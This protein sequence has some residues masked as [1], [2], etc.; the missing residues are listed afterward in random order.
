MLLALRLRGVAG[1]LEIQRVAASWSCPSASPYCCAVLSSSYAKCVDS[2]SACDSLG[3]RTLGPDDEIP[4][5]S[6]RNECNPAAFV[7]RW[8]CNASCNV[9]QIDKDAKCPD[10]VTGSATGSNEDEACREAKRAATQ[11]TPKGC[12]P[13]HC[14]CDC[15]KG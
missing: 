8:S 10:R 15:T 12:Y 5:F 11:S 6:F 14:Q 4:S 7:A 1:A 13:R 3:G 9:Q 2:A